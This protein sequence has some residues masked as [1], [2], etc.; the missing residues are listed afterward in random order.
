[1]LSPFEN[2]CVTWHWLIVLK[3]NLFIIVSL[4]VIW[5]FFI[6]LVFWWPKLSIFLTIFLGFRKWD[7]RVKWYRCVIGS[8]CM[9]AKWCLE[10][11]FSH[12]PSSMWASEWLSLCR[13]LQGGML[14]HLVICIFLCELLIHVLSIFFCDFYQ[15]IWSL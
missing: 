13:R 3:V 15:V 14:S 4:W 9:L 1:M 10:G 11:P 2:E 6:L 7:H 8:F 12:A 5:K